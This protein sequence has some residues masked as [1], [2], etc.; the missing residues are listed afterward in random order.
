MVKV[1]NSMLIVAVVADKFH[2]E[3]QSAQHSTGHVGQTW[4]TQKGV[5]TTCD[6]GLRDSLIGSNLAPSSSPKRCLKLLKH[7][8]D[9]DM[10]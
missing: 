3:Q 8:M 2:D 10:R 6:M 7:F 4:A 5:N 9:W 1:K